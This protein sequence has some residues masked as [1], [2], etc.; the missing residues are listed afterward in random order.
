MPPCTAERGLVVERACNR[1]VDVEA[2]A[3]E[4]LVESLSDEH[5]A[6]GDD[7]RRL[8]ILTGDHD[9]EILVESVERCEFCIPAHVD[10]LHNVVLRVL[11]VERAGNVRAVSQRER[12][13]LGVWIGL[14]EGDS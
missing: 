5:V 10:V 14:L 1:V 13:H 2:A 4:V 3:R 12:E 7:D 9:V 8:A 6:E 11:E